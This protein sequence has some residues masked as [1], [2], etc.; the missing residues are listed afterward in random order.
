MLTGL[1]VF[2]LCFSIFTNTASAAEM[3]SENFDDFTGWTTFGFE[4]YQSGPI[5]AGNFSTTGDVLTVLDDEV[6]FA[7][8]DSVTEVG[9]WSFDIYVPDSPNGFTGVAFM[10]NGSR[11]LEYSTEMIALEAT[12]EGTDRFILWWI[13]G[14]SDWLGDVAYTPTDSILGWHHIDITRTVGGTF[15]VFFNGTFEYTTLTNDVLHSTY[16]ECYAYNATGAMFDN[17]VV[18]DTIDITPPTTTP[19][20]TP[21]AIPW[22]LIAIGGGV[23]VVVIIL[24]IV[25][26]KRR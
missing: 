15:N 11:P 4:S 2:M 10:S 3:W 21:T 19:E 18:S 23:A 1:A 13:R 22:D 6:N 26:V 16:L 14:A 7:R 5:D 20:P 25:I 24:V 12:T 17:I 9:T 8:H